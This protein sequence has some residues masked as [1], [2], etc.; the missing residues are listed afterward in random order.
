LVSDARFLLYGPFNID[1]RFTSESNAQ[2]DAHLR[3]EDSN[4]GIRDLAVIES[5]AKLH[6]MQLENKLVMP[7]NNFILVFNQSS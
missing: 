2:F 5:L 6:H 3:A 4:M 7:A 1:G